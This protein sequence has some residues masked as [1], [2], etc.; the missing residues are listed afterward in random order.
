MLLKLWILQFSF[1]TQE[2]NVLRAHCPVG[3]GSSVITR[4]SDVTV[5]S[6]VG[7]TQTSGPV[8][9][10]VICRVMMLFPAPS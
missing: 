9:S 3:T 6:R 2:W 5:E 4:S 10:H 1:Q 7:I 8:V